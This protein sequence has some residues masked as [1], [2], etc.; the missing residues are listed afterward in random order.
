[1]RTTR[2][3]LPCVLVLGTACSDLTAPDPDAARSG[4]PTDL[5][6]PVRT[7]P[8][9]SGKKGYGFNI[10]ALPNGAAASVSGFL[11][12]NRCTDSKT[13]T[14]RFRLNLTPEIV[15]EMW[16]VIDLGG[17]VKVEVITQHTFTS[18]GTFTYNENIGIHGPGVHAYHSGEAQAT[19]PGTPS[20]I[21]RKVYETQ[22]NASHMGGVVAGNPMT[23]VLTATVTGDIGV[24][25]GVLP[26]VGGMVQWVARGAILWVDPITPGYP[27]EIHGNS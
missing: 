14:V 13:V 15:D 22:I 20:Q 3:L 19:N 12:A 16:D 9:L 21:T 6:A 5:V 18:M 26:I 1:M 23:V 27:V 10:E 8:T 2:F 25:C 11:P 17:T 24:A 7:G 4:F